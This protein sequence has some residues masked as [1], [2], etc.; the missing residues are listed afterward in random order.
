MKRRLLVLSMVSLLAACGGAEDAPTGGEN[1]PVQG[2]VPEGSISDAMIP[3]DQ[4]RSQSPRAAPL[5]GESGSS[6][7]PAA[8]AVGGTAGDAA[9]AP[10]EPVAT[11]E[12]AE[13]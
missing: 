1:A 10:A 5:P 11:P 7:S 6:P 9:P 3:V 2:E 8:A 4:I 12:P 13:E